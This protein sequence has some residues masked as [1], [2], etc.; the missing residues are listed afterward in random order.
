MYSSLEKIALV[1]QNEEIE[2]V[3]MT[4]TIFSWVADPRTVN[5]VSKN[6]TY[7]IKWKSLPAKL[8]I[9]LRNLTTNKKNNGEIL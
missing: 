9:G 8:R 1:L 6:G 5:I 7:K 3:Y 4:G 2:K